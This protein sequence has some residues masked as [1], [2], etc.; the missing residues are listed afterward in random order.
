MRSTRTA[1]ILAVLVVSIALTACAS[2]DIPSS[3]IFVAPPW[4]G[5]E[6]YSY[7]VVVRGVDGAGRCDLVTT[8]E[9]EPGRTLLQRLC[10]KDQ[11]TDNGSVLV[12]SATLRPIE[13]ERVNADEER[14]RRVTYRIVYGETEATFTADDGS[15]RRETTRRLPEPD[16]DHPD[17]GYYDDESLLWLARG[18]A[19]KDGYDDGYHHVINA[20][21]PRVLP[22]A[23]TITSQEDIETPAGKFRTWRVRFQREST[24]YFAWV[25]VNAPHVVVQ[26]R[27]EDATYRLLPAQ[28]A[29]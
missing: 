24:V 7:E 5:A 22:V 13:S 12:E 6:R 10:A 2:E 20:G 8:P 9:V 4:T 11:F 28:P 25:D 19:L 18:I 26:A 17:P 3:K 27:I 16:A 14:D 1:G 29:P 21:Q 23:V 15:T